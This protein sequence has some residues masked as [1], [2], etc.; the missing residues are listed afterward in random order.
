MGF[1][2]SGWNR[3]DHRHGW[4]H[5]RMGWG[6]HRRRVPFFWALPLLGFIFM[7]GL[8]SGWFIFFFVVPFI[9][10][11]LPVLSKS[12]GG[13][14]W[15]RD[16]YADEKRKYDESDYD[17]KPKRPTYVGDDGELADNQR[18]DEKRG[19]ASGTDDTIYYI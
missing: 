18:T 5:H 19:K 4:H 10:F 8:R 2:M 15:S 3:W 9:W 7:I 1:T 16:E 12:F 14:E 17:E 11:A 13:G 6:G